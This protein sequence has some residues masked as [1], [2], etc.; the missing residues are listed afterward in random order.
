[1]TRAD[2]KFDTWHDTTTS[3]CFKY[4]R[5][6]VLDFTLGS[7]QT[8]LHPA[9]C[10]VLYLNNKEVNALAFGIF[11]RSRMKYQQYLDR[12]PANLSYFEVLDFF[13][14]R[15]Q[16]LRQNWWWNFILKSVVGVQGDSGRE[17]WGVRVVPRHGKELQW[18]MRG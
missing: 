2:I 13:R 4:L 18:V 7:A 9:L 8:L 11:E 10:A 12:L 16:R 15:S 1:M 3:H 5:C 14:L 17:C 6:A